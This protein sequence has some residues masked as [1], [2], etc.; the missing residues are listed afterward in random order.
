MRYYDTKARI[1][2][3]EKKLPRDSDGAP[4]LPP[5]VVGLPDINP[6]FSPL[7]KGKRLT[8]DDQNIPNGLEDIPKLDPSVIIAEDKNYLYRVCY[9]FQIDNIDINL[10]N[11]MNKS[12]Y[13]VEAR[14]CPEDDLPL[15]KA[16]KDW[17]N[18]LWAAYDL[19]KSKIES[20]EEFST[21]FLSTMDKVPNGF[22]AV[23]DERK[24]YLL[25]QEFSIL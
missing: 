12:E 4:V 23:R 18:S 21:E 2:I 8:Y 14:V 11:E 9:K 13:L 6:F 17:L 16:N 15:A 19:Q 1:E 25:I 7:P 3:S 10:S 20:G 5:L 22:K 24:E